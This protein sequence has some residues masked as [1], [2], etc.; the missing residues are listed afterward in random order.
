M[1]ELI[2]ELEENK[3]AVFLDGEDLKLTYEGETLNT[4]LLE[5]VKTHK[6]GIISFLQK[7]SQSNTYADIPMAEKKENYPLSSSQYRIWLSCT[8]EEVSASYNV[9]NYFTLNEY[10]N[11]DFLI[12]AIENTVDRHETL[13]TV[14]K[15]DKNG[16]IR[17][18]I[19]SREEIGFNVVYRDCRE[20]ENNA[21][22]VKTHIEEDSKKVFNLEKGPLLRFYIYQLAED[23]LV[24]YCNMHHIISDTWS[25]GVLTKDIL[26]YYQSFT[27]NKTLDLPVLRIQYKDYAIW[28]QDQNSSDKLKKQ[29][30]FWLKQFEGDIPVLDLSTHLTRPKIKTHKGVHLETYLSEEIT[31]GLN[32]YCQK[33]GV[34]LY[35]GLLAVWNILFYRYTGAEDIVIGT[36]VAGRDHL[37]LKH[38]V[39]C[40]INTVALRNTIN[41]S[42]NFNVFCDKLKTKTLQSYEH[43]TYPFDELIKELDLKR[44]LS[45]GVLFDVMFLLQNAV[46]NNHQITLDRDKID[47]ITTTG[48]KGVVSDIDITI[49]EEGKYLKLDIVYDTAVY[50]SNLIERLMIHFRQLLSALLQNPDEAIGTVNYLT[51]KE[52][53][54]LIHDFNNT[55]MGFPPYQTILDLFDQQVTKTPDHIAIVFE[56][57]LITYKQLDLESNKLANFLVEKGAQVEQ[58][59][60]LCME[61]SVDMVIGILGIIKS[62]AAYVPIDPEYPEERINYIINDTKATLIL[63]QSSLH[64]K[65]QEN[66]GL[67]VINV[68]QK[69]Y[70]E[71]SESPVLHE[72]K[73]ENLIY[74][75]YTSGTT[76]KPKGVLVEHRGFLNLA[77]NQIDF[78]DVQEG[79]SALQFASVGFDASCSEIFTCLLAG[80][81]LVIPS[82]ETIADS[83]KMIA[84]IRKEKV[85]LATIPP[86]YQALII[87]ELANMKSIVSAGENLNSSV[88]RKLQSLGVRIINAYGP[89]ENSVCAT[90]TENPITED[91]IIN[92]G[93]PIGNT[94]IYI[95]DKELNIVPTGVIGEICLAG[96]QVARGYHN[97]PELTKEKFIKNP[98]SLE[99]ETRLYRTGDLGRWLANGTVEFI[100]RKDDQVKIR[101]YRIELREV[102]K[103]LMNI[104]NIQQAVVLVKEESDKKYMISYLI[105]MDIELHQIRQNLKKF[106]P[107]YM[108]PSKFL[109]LN[110]MPTTPNG[111]IDHKAL[112]AMNT[113]DQASAQYVAPSSN[114]E[115]VILEAC[116]E[117][118]K[119]DVISVLD[120]FYKI[121]GDSIKSIQLISLLKKYGYQLRAKDV[122]TAEDFRELATLLSEDLNTID[123]QK[124]VGD[125]LFTPIQKHFFK[126]PTF[127]VHHHYNQSVI[128]KSKEE[129]PSK[130][131]VTCIGHLVEH[132]DALRSVFPKKDG[133]WS[134]YTYESSEKA[135]S[136]DF[137]DL[138]Q[139]KNALETMSQLA[140][141]LQSSI[142]LE[143]GPL[144]KIGHFRLSDGDRLVLII[145]HLVVDGV[146]WRIL[147]MDLASL[148]AQFKN[149]QELFLPPKTDSF[150]KW[151]FLQNQYA[152]E[153]LILQERKYWESI[154]RKN[155]KRLPQ[156][157]EVSSPIV[158]Y[159]ATI[160]FKIDKKTTEI[161]QTGIHSIYQTEINSILIAA[162][163]LAIKE[164][165]STEKTMLKLEGHGRE[166][167]IDD[168]D[169]SRTVGWFTT[170]YPFL[171]DV[172]NTSNSLDAVLKIDKDLRKNPDKGIGYGILNYLT[173]EQ[174]TDPN[175][176]VEFNYLGDF[177]SSIQ[178]ESSILEYSSE[179]IGY[180]ID[181]SNGSDALLSVLGMMSFGQ[182]QLSIN[183]SKQI[184]KES[185]INRLVNKYQFYLEEIIEQLTSGTEVENN[186]HAKGYAKKG[187]VDVGQKNYV[188]S[189]NQ[190]PFLYK[191][192]SHGILRPIKIEWYTQETFEQTFRKFLKKYPFL[193]V[194]LKEIHGNVIQEVESPEKVKLAIRSKEN[195]KVSEYSQTQEEILNFFHQP[196]DLFKGELIR[197]FIVPEKNGEA[198]LFV[199]IHH[200]LTDMYSNQIIAGHLQDFYNKKTVEPNYISSFDFEIWQSNFLNSKKASNSKKFWR[201]KLGTLP[202]S[203]PITNDQYSDCI[204]E[205]VIVSGDEFSHILKTADYYG[206]PINA[207]I[208]T[209]HQRLLSSLKHIGK[210]LH[211]MI[212]DGREV[213]DRDIQINN[214]LGVV[215]NFLPLPI[216]PYIEMDELD[217]IRLVYEE[218]T[219]ARMHQSIPYNVMR[220]DIL[221]RTGN[222]IDFKVAGLFNFQLRNKSDLSIEG[223]QSYTKI[224]NKNDYTKGSDLT[225]VLYKNAI[226][227]SLT[228]PMQL[229]NL[230]PQL[231]MNSFLENQLL[232]INKVQ[233]KS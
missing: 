15:E 48:T 101:G 171:L 24:L 208:M 225:C 5:K 152:E 128:L 221:D 100:G 60:P 1:V 138:V 65:F 123:Q 131:L 95:L 4:G 219:Q 201:Q 7:Y 61:R 74:V 182:L 154:C 54:T 115:K 27:Q 20:I 181:P 92:I 63:S 112:L 215:C 76:G 125:V 163:G 192:Q 145:H 134:Q 200:I 127:V 83:S 82:N 44:D 176:S 165:F 118:L 162:L 39:G 52:K 170:I 8:S 211:L 72:L 157:I 116:K 70:K 91:G 148:F 137:Y 189:Y 80:G 195:F 25:L 231:Y 23:Q 28:H 31:T 84:L 205:K 43:Q 180:S 155:I 214:V 183:F 232:K 196:Y 103:T 109:I 59:I 175:P 150:Q 2:N 199:S 57:Q 153:P 99:T 224:H 169:I 173:N 136:I 188:L 143:K 218:Y 86:S 11:I 96:T 18:W 135:F 177:G 111:K 69:D 190:K 53:S 29:K 45:R 178:G 117:V 6:E 161:L 22:F 124:V 19:F 147:M 168:V 217:H 21:S 184:Y 226:E 67:Q 146:S 164:I 198:H 149:D 42:D 204:T 12:K 89:T 105:G 220:K 197:L 129:I 75:I 132:H 73:P 16:E 119:I 77:I 216:T 62:G 93:G 13:R 187:L 114:K 32:T 9:S 78:F 210:E 126:D 35:M 223:A 202:F 193:R 108:I 30:A 110:E 87:E 88:T 144:F 151:A 46:E 185:T 38:Q 139:E 213:L 102:Q 172:S 98:F 186:T 158:N 49:R 179:D 174:L 167:I 122:L 94:K 133:E 66:N 212:I 159:D 207:I 81:K 55:D 90:M 68:D 10:H 209:A 34:S 227:I 229:L 222:D 79:T 120:S 191:S 206:V 166:D 106:L 104:E 156:D 51:E 130:A 56:N 50:E 64:Q 203:D 71:F 14:F 121:G 58:M 40:F 230:Y 107:A 194:H 41:P 113:L 17:Q 36:A 142:N 33:Q 140:G 47:T 97:R 160:S 26:A 228:T 233:A 37:D 85:T 141:A 3:I